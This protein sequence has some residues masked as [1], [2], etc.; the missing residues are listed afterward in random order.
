MWG[1]SPR[2]QRAGARFIER[3]MPASVALQTVGL[4]RR[5]GMRLAPGVE[6]HVPALFVLDQAKGR[7]DRAEPGRLT[8]EYDVEARLGDSQGRDVFPGT[9]VQVAGRQ[10]S[11]S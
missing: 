5:C 2:R 10:P 11:Q 7:E 3:A 1:L 6:N 9:R 8:F 4:G